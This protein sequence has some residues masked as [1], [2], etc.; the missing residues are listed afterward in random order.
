L[1]VLDQLRNRTFIK[2]VI[3]HDAAA[4][5]HL[6]VRV[7]QPAPQGSRRSRTLSHETAHRMLSPTWNG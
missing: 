6:W 4:D 1:E 3:E 7:M 5:A 2:K